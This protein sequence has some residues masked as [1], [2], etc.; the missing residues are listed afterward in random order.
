MREKANNHL[1]VRIAGNSI[2]S[3]NEVIEELYIEIRGIHCIIPI[4]WVTDQPLHDIIIG[5]NFQRL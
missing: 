3:H 1:Q 4:L 2:I 5:N